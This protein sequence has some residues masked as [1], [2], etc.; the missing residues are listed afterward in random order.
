MKKSG[1]NK[2]VLKRLLRYAKPH[3]G[4]LLLALV[5]AIINVS[6]TL[7]GPILVGRAIDYVIGPDQ[8]D[9][10]A[11]VPVLITLAGTIVV[12]AA[13]QWLM[14]YC[15]NRVSYKTVR[16]LRIQTYEKI[17]TLPLKY[18]DGHAHGDLISRIVNDVDQVSD[19]LLQGITQLFT[20]V[21]TIVGT[22]LFMLTISPVITVVVVLVTPLSLFV[23]AFI[24]RLTHRQFVEQQATQGELSGFVEEMIGGQKTVKTFH[25]EGRAEERF[26]EI[27]GRLY[28]CG[29]KAQFYSSLSNPS[30]RFVNNM[31]YTAVAAFGAVCAITGWPAP[32]TIGQISSF[33][34]YANQYTKPFN[35]VTGVLTQIQTAF[36]SAERLFA[37]LDE[38]SERPDAPDAAVLEHCKGDV[39]VEHLYFSYDPARKLIEDMNIAA[40]SG[41]R[42]AIVGPTGCGK[43]TIINLLMRFYDADRGSISVDGHNIQSV[44]RNSLRKQY[45][46]VLQESWL[47]SGTVRENIAYGREDASLEE[48][49]AAAKKAHAHSFILR[50]PQGYDTVISEDGGNLSQGQRQLLCIARVMLMDPPMLILDEATSS[51]DTRTE[52][53]IQTAF[54]EMMRGRTSFIVAHRLSTIKGADLILVMNQGHIVEQGTHESLLAKGG[55]YANLYNSQFAVS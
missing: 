45:G 18:I 38:E 6:L 25:Y 40:K 28:D 14:T 37:V 17:N 12:S 20:G 43:T 50:L 2:S 33:L 5:S 53:K 16:D 48:V 19:G 47:F 52:W 51:I 41:S 32:L 36:A 30:T 3:A 34:T 39:T 27:N 49:V 8:V 9:F 10:A 22:L 55:F 29:V 1:I 54:E 26:K 35:E 23:A 46:M 13:F 15:T 24:A 31:V 42:I 21:V 44:T 7:Y 4:F 11:M